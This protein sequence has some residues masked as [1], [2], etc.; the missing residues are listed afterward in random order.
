[1]TYTIITMYI[2]GICVTY[3]CFSDLL[4]FQAFKE[5]IKIGWTGN[6]CTMHGFSG[7]LL[8]STHM[9]WFTVRQ[10]IPGIY[11]RYSIYIPDIYHA[12]VTCLVAHQRLEALDRDFLRIF[13]VFGHWEATHARLGPSK[14]FWLAQNMYIPRIWLT[15]TH[16]I[17]YIYHVYVLTWLWSS[18]LN[19]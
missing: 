18:M 5:A 2:H 7:Q 11:H 6:T 19:G 4:V 13:S 14:V 15:Y 1:M 16:E 9:A 12:K 10:D 3:T 8:D 17:Q